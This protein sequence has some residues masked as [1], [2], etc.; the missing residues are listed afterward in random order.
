M[1][2]EGQI[3]VTLTSLRFPGMEVRQGGENEERTGETHTLTSAVVVCVCV[4][5]ERENAGCRKEKLKREKQQV[6]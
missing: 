6:V 1:W 4:E 2:V 5:R 3:V